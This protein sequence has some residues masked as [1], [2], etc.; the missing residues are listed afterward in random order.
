MAHALTTALVAHYSSKHLVSISNP[1]DTAAT[2]INT[3]FIDESVDD[4]VADF[5]IYAW[6]QFDINN[7]THVQI[8]IEGLYAHVIQRH[9]A[10]QDTPAI[11][12][13]YQ[14]SLKVLK[15]RVPKQHSIDKVDSITLSVVAAGTGYVVGDILTISGGTFNFSP[16]KLRVTSV[17]GSGAITGIEKHTRGIY[18]YEPTLPASHTGGTGSG[19][20]FNISS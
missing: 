3:D 18:V 17:D 20:T 10:S 6:T 8:G 4:V 14:E 1:D 5:E 19:A 2:T 13:K 9:G 7:Q 16:W 15:R 11:L 12:T